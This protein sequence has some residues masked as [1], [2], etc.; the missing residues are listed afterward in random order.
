VSRWKFGVSGVPIKPAPHSFYGLTKPSTKQD[1]RSRNQVSTELGEGRNAKSKPRE[2]AL[3]KKAI[4]V[5]AAFDSGLCHKHSC[6][7][8]LIQR[9]VPFP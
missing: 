7:T 2:A 5:M 4:P 1:R 3:A 9:E 8:S 6:D